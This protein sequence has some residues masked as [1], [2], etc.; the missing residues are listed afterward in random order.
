MV[1]CAVA[2]HD[3]KTTDAAS[4]L[5]EPEHPGR[6]RTEE[7]ETQ[8]RPKTW[9]EEE[10]DG[11]TEVQKGEQRTWHH[12]RETRGAPGGRSPNRTQVHRESAGSGP[13]R[14]RPDEARRRR[15]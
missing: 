8:A 4:E 3:G 11:E 7:S 1:A 9:K 6:R 2:G 14:R 10:E 12:Q 13:C 15:L 5:K